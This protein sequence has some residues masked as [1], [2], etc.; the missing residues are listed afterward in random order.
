MESN[1]REFLPLLVQSRLFDQESAQAAFD[2]WQASAGSPTDSSSDWRRWLVEQ[3]LI[4]EY[5]SSLLGRGH[6]E[7]HFLGQYKILDRIGRGR[8]AGVYRASDAGGDHVAIKVL[9]PSKAKDPVLLARFQREARL[10]ERLDHPNVVRTRDVGAVDGFNFLVMEYLEGETLDLVLQRRGS[11]GVHEANDLLEQALRGLQHV[12]EKGMVHRDIKPANMM[13]VYTAGYQNAGDTTGA[14]LKLVDFGLSRAIDE[15]PP[16]ESAQDV[17][18]TVA[19]ALLGTPDYVAPEQA[20]DARS[21]DIRADIYSLGCVGYHLLSGHPPFPDKNAIRQMVRHATE[22][23]VP[24]DLV[25]PETPA[26]L[27]GVIERMLAKNPADRFATPGEA[28]NAME[29]LAFETRTLQSTPSR[30]DS[31]DSTKL[32]PVV[33]TPPAAPLN[34]AGADAPTAKQSIFIPVTGEKA[35]RSISSSDTPTD[36]SIPNELERQLAVTGE[37]PSLADAKAKSAP[38]EK[39]PP[40]ARNSGREAS[41]PVP[42]KSVSRSG[43]ARRS[44]Y[45]TTRDTLVFAAGAATVL[46]ALGIGALFSWLLHGK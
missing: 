31:S 14:T 43:I 46:T 8:M 10:A 29:S 45:W 41:P 4:T 44:F 3:K 42:S 22:P 37:L 35:D 30:A 16:P 33:D 39:R 23:P 27:R 15:V 38:A 25:R 21:A 17:N 26:Y 18:L 1:A 2:Q 9:P 36:A 7:G 20:R 19:G 40:S 11:L 12:H 32:L 5:Q 6:T 28:L 24:L 34:F 13:L